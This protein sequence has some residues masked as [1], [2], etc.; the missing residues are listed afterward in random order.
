MT[1]VKL[2]DVLHLSNIQLP[3]GVE[4]VAL[5]YGEGHDLAV[6]NV[7]APKG[8]IEEEEEA[9]AAA[10]AAEE[11]A[12]GEEAAPAGDEEKTGDSES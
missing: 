11:A 8:G 9:A 10:E 1:D 6:A 5:S 2:G 4:S 7:A 12:A 3:Q